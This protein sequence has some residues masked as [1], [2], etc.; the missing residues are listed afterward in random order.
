M[1][2]HHNHIKSWTSMTSSV[3]HSFIYPSMHPIHPVTYPLMYLFIHLSP[4][5]E[6]MLWFQPWQL[7]RITWRNC[8][9]PSALDAARAKSESLGIGP[10][11][12]YFLNLP[13]KLQCVAKFKNHWN[14]VLIYIPI[15]LTKVLQS[16][17]PLSLIALHSGLS[18]PG[19]WLGG[20][21]YS[22]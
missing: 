9:Y 6:I 22:V 18:I 11:H 19:L 1:P 7:S 3:V 13:P 8:K 20:T 5:Q 2:Y 15:N 12:R 4:I 14:D 17:A 16:T 10:G 21:E